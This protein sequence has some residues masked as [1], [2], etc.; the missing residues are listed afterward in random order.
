MT[1]NTEELTGLE[2][3][4]MLVLSQ[5]SG[6]VALSTAEGS[7]LVRLDGATFTVQSKLG[8][9]PALTQ[10]DLAFRVALHPPAAGI[11]LPSRFPGSVLPVLRAAPCTTIMTPLYPRLTDI[12]VLLNHL[13]TVGFCGMVTLQTG[14]VQA[15]I[16]VYEGRLAAAFYEEDGQVK[17]R[18]EALRALRARYLRDPQAELWLETLEPLIVQCLLGFILQKPFSQASEAPGSLR[19]AAE[20][21]TYLQ[22]GEPL[23]QV[24]AT[25][26]GVAAQFA[27]VSNFPELHFPDEP[28]GWEHRHFVL[29]LRGKDALNP[30]TDIAMQ[31]KRDFGN[32]GRQILEKLEFGL[33]A[34]GV[35]DYLGIELAELRSWLERFEKEGLVRSLP[36]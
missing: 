22:R 23:F 34:E 4:Q 14:V 27:A 19:C 5:R 8:R 13:T 9:A 32:S 18:T 29:T 7:L 33:T 16:L 20:G 24:V 12:R 2:F 30:I 21:Y 1:G 36:N 15:L 17:E 3:L 10:S 6:S 11:Q 26:R 35:A 31:F 28:P 25:Y